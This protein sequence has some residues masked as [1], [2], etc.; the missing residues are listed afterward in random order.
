MKKIL[1]TLILGMFLLSFV[2]ATNISIKHGNNGTDIIPILLT[3]EG[4]QLWDV[5]GNMTL[6]NLIVTGNTTSGW[7]RGL[8]NFSVVTDYFTFDGADLNFN[9]VLLNATITDLAGSGSSSGILNDSQANLSHLNVSE[10]LRVGGVNVSEFLFNQS[11]LA[12]NFN[13]SDFDT[14]GSFW[15]NQSDLEFNFNQSDFDTFGIWWFNQTQSLPNPFDQVL[16]TTSDVSFA[17]ALVDFLVAGSY[18]ESPV[19]YGVNNL[20]TDYFILSYIDG[21]STE[22]FGIQAGGN[23][24]W[25]DGTNPF[26]TYL[27]RSGVGELSTKTFIINGVN[28]SQY[29]FNQSD[30]EFNFNQSDITYN[31]NQ[32]DLDGVYAPIGTTGGDFNSTNFQGAFNLNFS[33]ESLLLNLTYANIQWGFNQ[34]DFNTFGSFW[35]NQSDLNLVYANIQWG[36][37]QSDLEF[38]FNQSE[39]LPFVET[40]SDPVFIQNF[41]NMKESCT[42]GFVSNGFFGNGSAICVED[43]QGEGSFNE[44]AYFNKSDYAANDEGWPTITITFSGRKTIMNLPAG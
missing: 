14:F 20:V 37:N 8:F 9:E 13:Q 25:G 7:F 16:N 21:D 28:A 32:S 6:D 12:Y 24:S 19:F 18:F 31:F 2:S 41:T 27:E 34:S 35:F 11:D 5:E 42:P 10:V 44:N 30:L 1:I 38:N 33:Q 36:F 17:S 39:N 43:A 22:S 23:L 4:K 29:L 15:Y 40:E 3:S 26:D